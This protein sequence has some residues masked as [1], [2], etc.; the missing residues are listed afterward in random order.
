[1]PN[2]QNPSHGRRPNFHRGRRSN[3]RRGTERRHAAPPADTPHRDTDVEQI[4]RDIRA[5]ISTRHGIDLSP[6]QIQELAARRLEAIL[7]PRHASP[8]LLEQM[9]RAAGEP[10]AVPEPSADAELPFDED[11]L[12]ESHRGFVRTLRRWLNP[13]LKLFFNPAPIAQALSAQ[14]VRNNAAAQREA[15]LYARQAEW[16]ALHYEIVQ[17]LVTELARTTLEMQTLT[18]RVEALDAKLDFNERRVRAMESAP[19]QH[20]SPRPARAVE[21]VPPEVAGQSQP[22]ASAPVTTGEPAAVAGSDSSRRRRRRRRG[23]RSG[24]GPA[25]ATG[26]AVSTAPLDNGDEGDEFDGP[27]GQD[28]SESPAPD[29]APDGV[30]TTALE[31]AHHFSLLQPTER[32]PSAENPTPTIDTPAARQPEMPAVAVDAAEPSV[33]AGAGADRSVPDGRHE[34][35]R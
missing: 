14:A 7:E 32:Y 8:A 15:E 13:I 30:D 34:P 11:A 21:F 12:Y 22:A 6:Q 20:S 26:A 18:L 19:Q 35:D 24:T 17:R 10:I 2:D 28:V 33:D 4:M 25:D 29:V 31:P 1:M 3:E 9:R 27:E 23:R 16:N 5:R